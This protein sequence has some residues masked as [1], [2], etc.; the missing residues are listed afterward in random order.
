MR[1]LE[2]IG[3]HS[4][5]SRRYKWKCRPASIDTRN[6]I[7]ACL[8]LLGTSTYYAAT[9]LTPAASR[10]NSVLAVAACRTKCNPILLELKKSRSFRPPPRFWKGLP[11]N[12]Y[13]SSHATTTV[14]FLAR[15]SWW[16]SASRYIERESVDIVPAG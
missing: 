13:A 3:A 16:C 7:S 15:P 5:V 2:E 8:G 14:I 4:Y 11:E 12:A 6:S 9:M 10:Q 1:R